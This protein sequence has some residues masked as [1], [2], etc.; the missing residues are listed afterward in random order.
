VA[1]CGLKSGGTHGVYGFHWPEGKNKSEEEDGA[2]TED[3]G[4]LPKGDTT[5]FKNEIRWRSNVKN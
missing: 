4:R 1:Q 2:P 3:A 5:V